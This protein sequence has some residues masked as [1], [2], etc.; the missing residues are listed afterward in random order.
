MTMAD[1]AKRAG[2]SV[3]TV[4]HVLNR[5]RSV[6]PEKVAAVLAAAAETGYVPDAVTRSMRTARQRMVG[7]AM[8]SISNAYFSDVVRGIE[9]A[10]RKQGY[11]ILLSETHDDPHQ[12]LRAVTELL[13][14]SVDAII[15]AASADPSHALT[16][17]EQRNVPVVLVDRLLPL[18]LD[19]IGAEG[20]DS[21]AQLAAHLAGHGHTR[22]GLVSGQEGL[23]TTVERIE[24]FRAGLQRS[25]LEVDDSLIVAG[26]GTV[27]DGE[28]A[29]RR[30]LDRPDRPTGVV[31]GNNLMT[32]GS[33]RAI[34]GLGLRIPD[35]VAIVAFD[36]FEWAD[37]VEP[38]LTAMAQPAQEMGEQAF[39]LVSDRLADPGRP[40]RRVQLATSFRRRNSCGCVA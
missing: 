11:S 31:L 6:A 4:S 37:L 7:L 25:G 2:V 18:E 35:D 12:E 21:T 39:E 10:A 13:S 36:D 24:G 22:I 17:C 38:Q 40:V 29:A 15:L 3:T 27:E 16:Y 8:S 33:L 26:G 9:G 19:Q 1:I 23:S 28:D 20:R 32:I 30:L 14:R 5:T 34:R